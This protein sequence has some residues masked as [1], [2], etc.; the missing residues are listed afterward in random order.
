MSNIA[1][2]VHISPERLLEDLRT[3]VRQGLTASPKW[4]SPKWFYDA[5]GSALFE[6]ITE[7]PEYYPTR[8]ERA[9]IEAHAYD[10]AERTDA[11]ILV[12]LGSGS[13]EKTRLLIAAGT[14]HGALRKYVPQDVSPSALEGA[15]GQLSQEF[16]SLEVQG[17]VSDFTDTLQN[18][19]ADGSRTI[20][21]LGGT[22]GNL[23]PEER[24]TFLAD[25][26][27]ALVA[28]EFLLLGV[29]LVI[30]EDVVVPAY[31]DAAGVTAQFNANVLSVLNDRLGA[32][33]DTESF[34]HVALWNAEAEW[35]EMRL[36][37]TQTQQVRIEDLDLDVTFDEGEELRNEISA[38]FRRDGIQRELVDAGFRIDEFWTDPQERFALILARR[39]DSQ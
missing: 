34:E 39:G 23:I 29:G 14:K 10:I 20:A 1:L 8:T 9:L 17:I 2:D 38:K 31:D 36:R 32:D 3:D 26:A 6:Q 24:A 30:D 27:Q 11:A 13:S 4:L 12:E 19:P 7:L 33:F 28:G 21:F 16:P 25:V 15:I 35:I 18:L 5:T 37:A 22:L